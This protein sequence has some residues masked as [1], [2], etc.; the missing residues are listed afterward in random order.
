MSGGFP[1]RLSCEVSNQWLN[2]RE[3]QALRST[4]IPPATKV[5]AMRIERGKFDEVLEVQDELQLNGM[6]SVGARVK[7]GGHLQLNGMVVGDLVID[8][9][10]T[11]VVNGTVSGDVLNR[12]EVQING[13]VAGRVEG[14]SN[15]TKIDPNAI[16]G[17]RRMRTGD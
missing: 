5:N 17:T 3:V 13:V 14:D 15:H 1:A 9:G 4:F 7:D 10:G 6:A 2:V 16:V 12:G 11:A 8:P